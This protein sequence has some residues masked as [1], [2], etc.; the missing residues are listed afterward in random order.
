MTGWSCDH[1]VTKED[2]IVPKDTFYNLPADK[3]DLICQ[4]AIAEFAEYEYELASINRIVAK[5]SI[6]KGSFYQ[7]FENKKE[8]YLYLLQLV[9]EEKVKYISPI[10]GNPDHHDIFTLLREMYISGIRF[11]EEHPDYAEIGNKLLRNKDAPIYKEAVNSNMPAAYEFF[12]TLL[13]GAIVTGEVRADI[14]IKMFAFMIASMST[15]VVEYYIGNVAQ[16][17]DE[18]MMA[19]FDKYLDF[20]KNGIG[21]RQST[22]TKA[23]LSSTLDKV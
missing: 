11:A 16:S 8:L 20:L 7:Y 5:S 12:E 3:R 22:V 6:S 17:Y 4:V 14:D 9:T 19:S 1:P 15:L 13:E 10:M 23:D 18:N 2:S 21:K